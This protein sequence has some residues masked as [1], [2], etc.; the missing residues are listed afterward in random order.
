MWSPSSVLSTMRPSSVPIP[1]GSDEEPIA[2]AGENLARQ[3]RTAELATGDIDDQTVTFGRAG[4]CDRGSEL[5]CEV[6]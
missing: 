3:A 1:S 5:R 2:A 6:E 4:N